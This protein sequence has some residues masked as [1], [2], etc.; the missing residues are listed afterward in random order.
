MI[1]RRF[2]QAFLVR[3]IQMPHFESNVYNKHIS[4][5]P[6]LDKKDVQPSAIL[7]K[8]SKFGDTS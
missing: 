8:F 6:T 4:G 2:A 7:G 5:V 1:N 3:E